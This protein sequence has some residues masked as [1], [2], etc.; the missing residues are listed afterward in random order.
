MLIDSSPKKENHKYLHNNKAVAVCSSLMFFF[1][2]NIEFGLSYLFLKKEGW[3]TR[4]DSLFSSS[5]I[6]CQKEK[7]AFYKIDW[8]RV[9]EA[10]NQCIL[11]FPSK[12]ELLWK[13]HPLTNQFSILLDYKLFFCQFVSSSILDPK[14]QMEKKQLEYLRAL[15][16]FIKQMLRN[17]PSNS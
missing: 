17:L 14:L 4:E 10:K 6:L 9:K 16:P 2:S 13:P 12:N 1:R 5:Y 8:K 15:L 3:G 7:N 11:S